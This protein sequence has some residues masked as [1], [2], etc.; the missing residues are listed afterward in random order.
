MKKK[1]HMWQDEQ[2]PNPTPSG[3]QGDLASVRQKKEQ[4]CFLAQ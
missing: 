3:G 2:E 4:K 1:K